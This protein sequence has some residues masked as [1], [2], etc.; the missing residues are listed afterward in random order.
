M[1]GNPSL[2]EVFV[3]LCVARGEL[4]V[5]RESWLRELKHALIQHLLVSFQR[6]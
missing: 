5:L 6:G 2:P 4:D 3:S 1:L